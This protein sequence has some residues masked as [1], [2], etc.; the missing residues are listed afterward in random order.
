MPNRSGLIIL[1]LAMLHRR[2]I[3]NNTLVDNFD[4][5]PFY[6]NSVGVD[7]LMDSLQSRLNAN[8]GNYP[9]YN[10]IS[11]DEDHYVIE[12]AIAGFTEEDVS[13]TAHDGK[14][15]IRGELPKD[16]AS[17]E[18]REDATGRY[19]HHGI[20]NRKFKRDFQL[21]D[22]IEVQTADLSNGILRIELARHLPESL[23]PKEIKINAVSS[24]D[25]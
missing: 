11:I 23:Q 6:R 16:E 9:P 3:M 2:N 22:Y 4:F 15:V 5:S 10:I 7:R 12:I 8:H 17:E 1:K 20:S 25:E 13:V 24:I 14:L 19:L 21:A 18:P